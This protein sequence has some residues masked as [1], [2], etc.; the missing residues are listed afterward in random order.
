MFIAQYKVIAKKLIA[1]IENGEFNVGDYFPADKILAENY[2]VSLITI[3]NALKILKEQGY[4]TRKS[5]AKT[6]VISQGNTSKILSLFYPSITP[7]FGFIIISEFEK[8]CYENGYTPVITRT[9]GDEFFEKKMINFHQSLQ[10]QGIIMIPCPSYTDNS[11]FVELC[12]SKFPIV[13]IDREISQVPIPCISTDVNYDTLQ[14][15]NDIIKKNY[16]DVIIVTP[17]FKN[18]SVIGDRVSCLIEE[19]YTESISTNFIFHSKNINVSELTSTELNT[20]MAEIS[21]KL[22]SHIDKA[23]VFLFFE[24]A[25]QYYVHAINNN[26]P[27]QNIYCYDFPAN[28]DHIKINHTI[29]DEKKLFY[30]AVRLL[31]NINRTEGTIQNLKIPGHFQSV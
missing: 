20:N 19:L 16:K 7:S 4:I 14:I 12:N 29:Q 18:R 17:K 15:S 30:E 31:H 26:I 11:T 24:L 3:K 8:Y 6:T 23:I 21:N 1:R 25:E 13:T 28:A 10:T 27:T 2:N 5:G 22:S 9:F